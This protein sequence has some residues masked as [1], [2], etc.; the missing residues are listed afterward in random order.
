VRL[1]LLPFVLLAALVA[2]ASA[3][4]QPRCLGAAARDPQHRCANPALRLSVRPA[5]EEAPLQPGAPCTPVRAVDL[6]APCAFGAPAA[7]ARGAIALI[8]DSHAAHWRPALAYVAARRQ[9]RAYAITR[10]SCAFSTAGRELAEPYR[11]QCETWK[12][13]LPGWLADHPW[14]QTVFLA[15][16]TRDVAQQPFAAAMASYE[17]AWRTLPPSVRR[18]VVI[19]DSPE[20]RYDTLTCVGRAHARGEPAGPACAIPRAAALPADPAA[21]AAEQLGSERVRSVDLT[22]FFC[23]P[24]RCFPVVGGVLVYKDE[25]HLTPLFARTLG[26]YLLR[27]VDAVLP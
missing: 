7:A 2:S 12:R 3:R 4:A 15:S 26:P 23:G 13:E 21:A 5:P 19:R 14:V 10:D 6:V 24:S 1:R 16:L 25:N 9:L 17:D 11:S 18:I 8:G 27:A 20:A 22:S